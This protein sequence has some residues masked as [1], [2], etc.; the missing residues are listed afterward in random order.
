MDE[1]GLLVGVVAFL[2]DHRARRVVASFDVAMREVPVDLDA[3]RGQVR[4]ALDGQASVG[5]RAEPPLQDADIAPALLSQAPG[6]LGARPLLRARAER[7]DELLLL[8]LEVD[9]SASKLIGLE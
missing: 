9:R 1:I 3:D 5:P 8:D 2:E 4:F 6:D 7:D